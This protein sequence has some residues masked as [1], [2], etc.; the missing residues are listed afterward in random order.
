MMRKTLTHSFLIVAA[1]A[2]LGVPAA[3]AGSQPDDFWSKFNAADG[4]GNVAAHVPDGPKAA[5]TPEQE[6]QLRYFEAQMQISDGSA[7][8]N[9]SIQDRPLVSPTPEQAAQLRY[10]E[11]QRQ[12]SDGSGVIG[13]A[14]ASAPQV[15]S[16]QVQAL[17]SS[18][19]SVQ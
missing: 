11:S 12:I 9:A 3:Y 16:P 4:G 17:G 2:A 6:A 7:P 14:E 10:F 5:A 15:S 13:S 18:S 1:S 19:E 8:P